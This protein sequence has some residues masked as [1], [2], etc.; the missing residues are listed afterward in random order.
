MLFS[1]KE[2][3]RKEVGDRMEQTMFKTLS[4]PHVSHRRIN[5]IT[6]IRVENS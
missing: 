2:V 6:D 3:E 5:L 1:R 4:A